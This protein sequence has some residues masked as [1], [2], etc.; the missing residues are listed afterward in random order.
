MSRSYKKFP[1]CKDVKSGKSGK[2]IANHKVRRQMK[3]GIDIPN[4]N[5]YQKVF[6]SWDIYDYRFYMT[7]KDVYHRWMK[8][9]SDILNGI[10]PWKSKYRTTLEE[11]KLDW[12]KR[13]KRK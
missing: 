7:E 12:F 9:K 13:Y 4:G 5:A 2:K 1:S 10:Y 8:E 11:D 3:R 6:N